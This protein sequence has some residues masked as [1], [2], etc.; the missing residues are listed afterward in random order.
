MPKVNWGGFN[1]PMPKPKI[2]IRQKPGSMRKGPDYH[3]KRPTRN[4]AMSVDLCKI[5][6]EPVRVDVK[7]MTNGREY[8]LWDVRGGK[9]H[10]HQSG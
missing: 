3:K 1:D 10:R 6:G 2:K 5:C 7:P 4:T 9:L 8:E